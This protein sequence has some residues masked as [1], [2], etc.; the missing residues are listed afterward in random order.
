MGEGVKVGDLYNSCTFVKTYKSTTR[1]TATQT[2]KGTKLV[3]RGEKSVCL[4]Q[5]SPSAGRPD[6]SMY[7]KR[8]TKHTN[9]GSK[10]RGAEQWRRSALKA[11]ILLL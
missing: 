11:P 7:E 10:E 9:D 4:V 2:I 3:D 8:M 1:T 6:K 5:F